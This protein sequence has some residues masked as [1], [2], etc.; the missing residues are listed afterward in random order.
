[1]PDCSSALVTAR[2][3]SPRKV[4]PSPSFRA[5]TSFLNDRSIVRPS[6]DSWEPNYIARNLLHLRGQ[7]QRQDREGNEDDQADKVG[8]DKWNDALEDCRKGDVLDHA[9]NDEHIHPDNTMS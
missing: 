5:C 3:P 7:P 2:M 9:F 1:M 4:S 8:Q 6:A